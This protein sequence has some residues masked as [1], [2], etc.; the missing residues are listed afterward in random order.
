LKQ[1]KSRAPLYLYSLTMSN[2]H[3]DLRGLLSA[4]VFIIILIWLLS[5]S[6]NF[7]LPFA[8]RRPDL[9]QSSPPGPHRLPVLGNL[10]NIP[11][12]KAWETYSVWRKVRDMFSRAKHLEG[13]ALIRRLV[14]CPRFF[15]AIDS[16]QSKGDLIYLSVMGQPV[17]VIN[18]H[19]VA[20]D[21]LDKRSVIYSGRP[22]FTMA[23]ELWVV[24]QVVLIKFSYPSIQ[25][26]LG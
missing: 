3:I 16:K 4:L 12:Y 13:L 2:G 23:S 6:S 26:R 5:F 22:T 1:T 17:I 9:R 14:G 20:M 18:S 11:Q 7:H 19:K 8:H 15:W 10:F 25:S 24:Y 21:L